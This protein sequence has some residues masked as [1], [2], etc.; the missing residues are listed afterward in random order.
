MDI[1]D[2]RREL[3]EWISR[4][5]HGASY[6]DGGGQRLVYKVAAE[7]EASALKIWL[8]TN[9]AQHERH[10]REVSAL[11][12]LQH[13]NLP[14]INAP[15]AQVEIQGQLMAFY[16][17]Q[18][19][20]A[21]SLKSQ[22]GEFPLDE[23]VARAYAY[24]V[25]AALEALHEES[26]VHRDVSL[27]NILCGDDGVYLIDLGLAKHLE[28]DS[29]TRPGE[30]LPRTEI[31]ASPEQLQGASAELRAPTDIFSLGIVLAM[32]LTG[33]HPFFSP[34]ENI[35]LGTLI[36]RQLSGDIRNLPSS[37]LGDLIRKMLDPV[38]IFRP[39]AAVVRGELE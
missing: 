6:A 39:S 13:P 16:Q 38:V 29:L 35:Q 22:L 7:G 15:I 1:R 25:A 24:G 30:L 14:R 34:S 10:V 11:S 8:V 19:L 31:S 4:A 27:G 18:W 9:S 37:A 2:F 21:P 26:I 12:M 3:D 17:E 5:F 23:E 28:L 36:H 20:E 33:E 32:S